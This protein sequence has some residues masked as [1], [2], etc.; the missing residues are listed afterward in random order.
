MEHRIG[1]RDD[2]GRRLLGLLEAQQN[3]F[4][5]GLTTVADCGLDKP[6]I[7]LIDRLQKESRLK[8]RLYVMLS[9]DPDNYAYYLEKGPY[10]TDYLDVRSFKLFADGALGSRGACLLQPYADQ[11]G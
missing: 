6:V 5:A 7:D 3:C 11:P 9:D 1:N 2:L 10:K 4:A 8:I